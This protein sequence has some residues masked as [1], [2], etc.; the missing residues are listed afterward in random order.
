MTEIEKLILEVES[1]GLAGVNREL[2]KLDQNTKQAQNG[3]LKVGDS[4][5]AMSNAA[6]VVVNVIKQIA[7]KLY[8]S[9][10]TYQ[11]YN[12]Q[13]KV[14]T[15]SQKGAAESMEA[16]VDFAAK[17]PFSVD[18][19]TNSFIKLVNLGLD[20]SERAMRAHGNTAVSMNKQLTEVIDAV[21]RASVGEFESLKGLGILAKTQG[22]QVSFT[23]QNTTT[24]V[25]KNAKAIEGYLVGLGEV[26]FAGGMEEQ[27]KGLTGASSNLGDAWD[28]LWINLSKQGPDT[29]ITQAFQLAGAAVADF[30]AD[31]ASGATKSRV[32]AYGYLW[33]GVTDSIVENFGV[34]TDFLKGVTNLWGF[35]GDS[36]SQE[37]EEF[38]KHF[39]INARLACDIVAAY[40]LQLYDTITSELSTFAGEFGARFD[41]I[42]G[43][44]EAAGLVITDLLFNNDSG[45]FDDAIAAVDKVT[46]AKLA[47]LN[48]EQVAKNE[49]AQKTYDDTLA[50]LVKERDRRVE[51]YEDALKEANI[52]RERY[53]LAAQTRAQASGDRLAKFGDT[54]ASGGPPKESKQATQGINSRLDEIANSLAVEGQ[55]LLAG[56]RTNLDAIAE[57]TSNSEQTRYAQGLRLLEYSLQSETEVIRAN[58]DNRIAFVQSAV[59]ASENTRTAI[60]LALTR[61][62]EEEVAKIE[63]ESMDKKLGAASTF[64]GNIASM[65]GT[66]GKKGFKIAQAAAIAQATVDTYSAATGAYAS[67]AKIPYIGP[68]LGIAAAA[69]VAGAANVAKIK[70]QSYSGAYEHGGLIPGGKYGL[71][72]EAGPE[73]V[74]GPAV[75]TSAA[76]TRNSASTGGIRTVTVHNNGQPVEA[77]SRMNGDEL[78]IT[79]RPL[80]AQAKAETKTELAHE[81]RRGGSAFSRAV[82]SQYGLSRAST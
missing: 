67:L 71:V 4:F 41:Q 29:L 49:A 8:E 81:V 43:Y 62:R 40:F 74:R 28:Q 17:T 10:K 45:N 73:Y 27:M 20:P 63:Q 9:T 3:L 21:A 75:V 22:D 51:L 78:M 46:E 2:A 65:Q 38:F 30:N 13:L 33:K 77:T 31:L 37:F 60:V 16:L 82:E 52:L 6:L 79:L 11:T 69:V 5:L 76:T 48:T 26:Q 55:A 7:V 24:I 54:G 44:A 80:L 64:F 34:V 12:A 50:M 42:V 72:G 58:F 66:F 14:A 23:F 35:Y 59:E 53:D 25:E 15:K 18:Q 57:L 70:S 32:V 56:T 68:A 39:P 19:A 1:K 36:A 61:K 47:A